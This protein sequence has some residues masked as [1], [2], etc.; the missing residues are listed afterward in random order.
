MNLVQLTYAI[1]CL[2]NLGVVGSNNG[3][4]AENRPMLTPNSAFT[5]WTAKDVEFT[6]GDEFKINANNGWDISFSGTKITDTMNEQVYQVK[7]QDG[8]DNLQFNGDSGKYDV[9]V[10]FSAV[11][12]IVTLKKK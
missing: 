6:K 8:G 2:D 9:T 11:P 5:I 3:W 1:T 7:K 12:Y 4:D 10:D